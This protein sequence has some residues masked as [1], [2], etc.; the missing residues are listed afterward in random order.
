MSFL[1]FSFHLPHVSVFSFIFFTLPLSLSLSFID[2]LI[3]NA[4]FQKIFASSKYLNYLI[5]IYTASSVDE[6]CHL[7]GIGFPF[8]KGL[9]S[10]RNPL[11]QEQCG[12]QREI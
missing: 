12:T 5:S 1:S 8:L 6:Y 2:H 10:F 9:Q 3:L 4:V 11:I 7:V